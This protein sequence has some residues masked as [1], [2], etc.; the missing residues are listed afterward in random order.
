MDPLTKF[1]SFNKQAP[2]HLAGLLQARP[3]GDAGGPGEAGEEGLKEEFQEW[4][5]LF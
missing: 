1:A 2:A 4:P 3:E 5:K